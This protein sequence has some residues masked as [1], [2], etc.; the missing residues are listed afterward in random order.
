[1]STV[2]GHAKRI[3]GI[4]LTIGVL[5]LA[6]ILALFVL[7]RQ[8]DSPAQPDISSEERTSTISLTGIVHTEIRNGTKKL[9][10]EAQNAILHRDENIS[11]LYDLTATFYNEKGE[12]VYLAAESGI[13]MGDIEGDSFDLEVNGNVVLKNEQ[14]EMRT[15]TLTY[16]DEKR[17]FE[18]QSPVVIVVSGITN[19]ADWMTYNLDSGKINGINA[20]SNVKGEF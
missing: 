11:K 9:Q 6:C 10:L 3:K 13:L 19:R 1:M 7:R 16:N 8:N 18:T 17:E 20:N 12:P 14:Y 4:L 5:I 15:E 2:P